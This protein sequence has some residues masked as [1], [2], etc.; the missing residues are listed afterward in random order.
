MPTFL[1]VSQLHVV[2]SEMIE[3]TNQKGGVRSVGKVWAQVDVGVRY[4]RLSESVESH[5]PMGSIVQ[6]VSRLSEIWTPER[7]TKLCE[8]SLNIVEHMLLDEAGLMCN[9]AHLNRRHCR[10]YLNQMSRVEITT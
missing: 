1:L 3:Q 7:K 4:K 6:R 2:K 8:A 10:T 9:P 5:N